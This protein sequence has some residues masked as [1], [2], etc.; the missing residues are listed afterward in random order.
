MS[1]ALED[2]VAQLGQITL[3]KDVATRGSMKSGSV[4]SSSAIGN[5]TTMSADVNTRLSG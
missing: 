2:Y 1:K 5:L 4:Q 3:F